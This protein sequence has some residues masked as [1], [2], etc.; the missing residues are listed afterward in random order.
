MDINELQRLMQET[1]ACIRAIPLRKRGILDAKAKALFPKGQG[2]LAFL[3]AFNREMLVAEAIPEH[4][5][6]F[7][8]KTD[9]GIESIAHVEKDKYYDTLEEAVEVL[10]NL[11]AAKKAI[12]NEA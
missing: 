10:A 4:A 11:A 2:R 6:K 7:V 1:G 3:P 8:I 5:G 9:C 12:E